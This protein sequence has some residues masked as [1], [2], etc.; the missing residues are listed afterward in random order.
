[1]QILLK[2]I[3]RFGY[4]NGL[5]LFFRI[6]YGKVTDLTITGFKGKITLRRDSVDLNV[7]RH[8][9]VNE[10]YAINLSFEPKVIIDAGAFIGL[11]TVDFANRYPESTIIAVEPDDDNFQLL[12]KNI[13]GYSNVKVIK[14]GLWNEITRIRNYK[15]GNHHCG[16]TI[17]TRS[18]EE[19]DSFNAVTV[20]S[21]IQ[22][23][24]I[25]TIDL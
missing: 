2:F 4:L 15:Q 5:F 22:D 6:N 13:N 18:E 24:D 7:F 9:I 23:Y 8:V 14:S 21:I 11:S 12:T 20:N 1:M 16:N 25:D 3:H 17:K 10:D 19:D